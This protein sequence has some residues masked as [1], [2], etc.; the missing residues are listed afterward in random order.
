[1]IRPIRLT[2]SMHGKLAL[3]GS[4]RIDLFALTQ[5]IIKSFCCIRSDNHPF[6]NMIG[7]FRV[8]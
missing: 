2:L 1:M 7:E 3:Q 6:R 8:N 5:K 4:Y